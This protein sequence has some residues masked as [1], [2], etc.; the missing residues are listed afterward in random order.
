MKIKD[1][2]CILLA[3][4]LVG[5]LCACGNQDSKQNSSDNSAQSQTEEA[6]P[7]QSLV[8]S[9][10]PSAI[11]SRGELLVGV[12]TEGFDFFKDKEGNDSGYEVDIANAIAKE[13]GEEVKVKFVNNNDNEAMLNSLEKGEIDF[14]I[15]SLV[16]SPEMKERFNL[17]KSY[18]PWEGGTVS[19]FAL[20]SNKE[21]FKAF[22]DFE[23]AKIAVVKDTDQEAM[24]KAELPKASLVSCSSINECMEKV[25]SGEADLMAADDKDIGDSL[26]DNTEIINT[27]I[28]IPEVPEDQGFF[29]VMMKNNEELQSSINKVITENRENGNIEEWII[30]AWS[31]FMSLSTANDST[32]TTAG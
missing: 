7:Q 18:W 28:T 30:K 25:K 2:K 6:I 9:H 17:S 3:G 21:K 31:G 13:I 11:K 23:A 15:G 19:T 1:L 10:T 22:S 12:K 27:D 8:T 16:A 24:V 14:A 5:G 20:Q 26:K 32:G 4:L 29:I